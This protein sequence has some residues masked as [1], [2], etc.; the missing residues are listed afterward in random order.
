MSILSIES[1]SVRYRGAAAVSVKDV[2]CEINLGEVVAL[3][4]ENGAGKSTLIHTLNGSL[5]PSNGHVFMHGS[6]IV[7]RPSIAR[8]LTATMRQS[9]TPIRGMTPRQA[10]VNAALLR[11]MPL[12]ESRHRADSLFK[13]LNME[14]QAEKPGESLSGGIRRLTNLAVTLVQDTPIVLLDEPTNDVDPSRRSLLW[15]LL[16]SLAGQNKLVLVTTHNISEA[17]H[18][19]NR[20]LIM[21]KGRIVYDGSVSNI[22]D[23]APWSLID[24]PSDTLLP[25]SLEKLV[26]A[27]NSECLTLSI[28]QDGEGLASL[29]DRL[30]DVAP[31]VTV[32]RSRSF[33]SLFE[34]YR[35]KEQ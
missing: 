35:K 13:A 34:E 27:K 16:A 10:V 20:Q 23:N 7:S 14:D 5:K 1:L 24:V 31:N 2:S 9:N 4:G 26:V 17:S 29:L 6:D 8:R 22:P 15:K 21:I 11:G 19:T 28:P 30:R 25:E 3:T 12:K 32:R 18:Y 33:E